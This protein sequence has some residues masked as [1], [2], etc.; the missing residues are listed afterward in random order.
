MSMIKLPSYHNHTPPSERSRIGERGPKQKLWFTTGVGIGRGFVAL[1]RPEGVT[2]SAPYPKR[3]SPCPFRQVNPFFCIGSASQGLRF[4]ILLK[5]AT[6]AYTYCL[7][8]MEPPSSLAC[9][10]PH[11]PSPQS[12]EVGHHRDRRATKAV[13]VT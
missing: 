10:T 6:L 9:A 8:R 4:L 5:A 3:I 12:L 13:S 1:S 7:P 2:L 11:P